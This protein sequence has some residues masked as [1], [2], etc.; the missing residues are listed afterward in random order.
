MS[1][2]E[3]PQPDY[4]QYST[5]KLLAIP[6]AVFL[7]AVMILMFWTVFT[8]APFDRAMVFTGGS[9]VRIDVDSD[10]VDDPETQIREAF[11]DN[12]PES[13]TNVPGTGSYIVNFAEGQM[14]PEEIE[15]SIDQQEGLTVSELSTVTPSLGAD[16]QITA[17][18]GLL[19]AFGLMSLLVITL[20]RS[21]I[22]AVVIILSAVS[23]IVIAG[24]AMNI[25]GIQLSMGTV[26]ALLMLIGYSVDSDILLNRYVLKGDKSSFNER[27]HDAIRTGVTMTLTSLSAMVVMFIVASL[28]GIQ[29][30]ADMGFV[31]AVGLAADLI[32]TYMMNVSILRWYINRRD[33]L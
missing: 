11:G 22:P 28:F 29:L 6:V 12:E 19:A 26:G 31:L 32:N 7:I 30:L 23:N 27:V 14:T 18:Y 2:F 16:A 1:Y 33:M 25:A 13:V 8:G 9:E 20:F 17:L 21:G 15:D 24:A 3:P 5:K 4:D 10:L